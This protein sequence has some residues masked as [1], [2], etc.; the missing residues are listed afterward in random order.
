MNV[1]PFKTFTLNIGGR[2]F[3]IDS[4]KIMG[5]INVT[6]DSFYEYSFDGPALEARAEK[7]MR[8]GAHIID[9]GG[10]STRPGFTA[11]SVDE[12]TER[13]VRGI[14]TVRR[15]NPDAVISVDTFRAVVAR[16]AVEVGA[17]IIND[18]SG[19]AD[20]EMFETVAKLGVPYILTDGTLSSDAETRQPF[21]IEHRLMLLAEKLRILAQAGV[22]DVIV[23]PGF[24]FGKTT[25]DN[26]IAM[27]NLHAY[28]LL[29]R[30]LLVGISRKSMIT[31]VCGCSSEESLA[32]TV[33]LNTFALLNG[34]SILR[35]HDVA[36]ARQTID[37]VA[38]LANQ[39]SSIC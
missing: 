21:K 20:P 28:A 27:S 24:G 1:S 29:D 23:D 39:I 30:P 16:K 19:G 14:E 32:G 9:I 34:A 31:R 36:A 11:P 7:M 22:A 12:E 17:N 3:V 25:D 18:V 5:I 33:A 15:I 4:P 38:K 10:C 13:V 37:I 35:V 8:D 26:Y 6:P 2:L